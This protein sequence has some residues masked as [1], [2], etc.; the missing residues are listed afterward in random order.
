MLILLQYFISW[1][2]RKEGRFVS[3][4]VLKII[5]LSYFEGSILLILK[6]YL[7]S[8]WGWIENFI[9]RNS[10]TID[11]NFMMIQNEDSEGSYGRLNNERRNNG[12]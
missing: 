2:V 6:K 5:Y 1:D 10:T 8:K 12:L 4:N 3:F 11:T 9:H 7:Q